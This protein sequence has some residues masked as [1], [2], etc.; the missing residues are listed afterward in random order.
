MPLVSN[1]STNPSVR[2]S[3]SSPDPGTCFPYVTKTSLPI[4]WM[5]NGA[6]PFGRFGSVN[7]PGAVIWWKSPSNTSTL[8]FAKSVAYSR[9]PSGVDA[10]AKPLKIA[11]SFVL[12]ATTKAC[13]D[14]AGGGTLGFHPRICP[15]SVSNRNSDGPEWVPSV[16]TKSEPPLNTVPVGSSGTLTVNEPL[17]PSVP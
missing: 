5:P 13:V 7:R 4:V 11:P 8:A 2:P 17:V 16:T 14:G 1:S 10:I 3:C 12:S 6:Y 9:S 15:A